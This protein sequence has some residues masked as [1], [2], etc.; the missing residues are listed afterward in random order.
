[1]AEIVKEQREKFIEE[2]GH[3]PGPDDPVFFDMPHP[4][5][6]EAQMVED[7]QKAGINPAIIYAFEQTGLLVTELNQH[8]IPE[9]DLDQWNAAI[10]EFEAQQGRS[11]TKLA[12]GKPKYPFGN[13]A[14]Y[15]PDDQVTTKIAAAVIPREGAEPII[16]RWVGTDVMTNPKV[17]RELHD[18][19]QKHNVQSVA[20]TDGN[21]GCPHEEGQDYPPG[22]DCPSCPFW[23]REER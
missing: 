9:H 4:E 21:I 1:M 3:E 17:Q 6:L 12:D 5:H 15:G 22:E 10:F 2:F 18:F 16:E 13:V 14:L 7:M 20:M 8:L 23:I 19:F 11:P